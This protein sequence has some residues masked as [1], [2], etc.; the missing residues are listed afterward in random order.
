M[1]QELEPIDPSELPPREWLIGTTL[2]RGE[3]TMIGSPGG[4]GKTAIIMAY[5]FAFATGREDI[6]GEHIFQTGKVW[7]LTLEDDRLEMKR[8][9]AALMLSHKV[10]NADLKGK[11]WLNAASDRPIL[12]AEAAGENT[13]RVCIDVE[14][15]KYH[16]KK[17][18]IGLVIIDPLVKSHRLNEIDNGQLDAL[19]T[20]FNGIAKETGCAV[21]LAHHFRKPAAGQ[22]DTGTSG[23]RGGT[24]LPNA[25]RVNRILVPMTATEAAGKM[26][27]GERQGGFGIPEE[28]AYRYIRFEDVKANL[29]PKEKAFWFELHSTPLGNTHVNPIYTKGDNVQAAHRWYPGQ[30]LQNTLDDLTGDMVRHIFN[31]WREPYAIGGKKKDGQWWWSP[32]RNGNHP[33]NGGDEM[34][35]TCRWAGRVIVTTGNVTEE[36]AARL[37]DAWKK[38]GV[39]TEEEYTNPDYAKCKR[40]VLNDNLADAMVRDWP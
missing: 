19:A 11:V 5:G 33:K 40:L 12:L 8:R 15:I 39:W 3:T 24:S 38:A 21:V 17:L 6:V 2:L 23:F 7:I 31:V 9:I 13:I 18:G 10:S 30:V 35:D 16:V 34:V 1:P 26:V 27:G 22:A 25:F 20:M 36:Q 37:L 32:R 29:A 14:A 4:V 28:E